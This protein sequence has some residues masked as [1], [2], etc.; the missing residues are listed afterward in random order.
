MKLVFMGR[1]AALAVITAVLIAG[2][3]AIG[4]LLSGSIGGIAGA[5][6]VTDAHRLAIVTASGARHNFR[7][8]IAADD[9]KRAE[10]LMYRA[11][12]DPDYGML[13]DFK[14]E[15]TV[16]FWMKNTYVSLDMIFVRADGTIAKIAENTTPLSEATVPSE[17]PVRFVFEVMA[18]TTKRLGVKAGD[19]LVHP[20]MKPTAG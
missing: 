14:R 6:Q 9:D 5:E 3:A 19:K 15:Q 11:K 20:L 8:E 10:G 18:G 2:M 13:F 12:L 1:R 4:Y 7:I 16:Y 17:F